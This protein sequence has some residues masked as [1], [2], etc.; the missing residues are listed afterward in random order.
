MKKI[1]FILSGLLVAMFFF[2][3]HDIVLEQVDFSDKT[4]QE[5]K[6]V[7]TEHSV[8]HI[9]VILTID[10]SSFFAEFEEQ[11]IFS[12]KNFILNNFQP[13]LFKPPQHA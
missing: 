7:Q 3:M 9:P 13:L 4:N 5:K 10:E 2:A 6:L 8:F 12:S 11:I 1:K